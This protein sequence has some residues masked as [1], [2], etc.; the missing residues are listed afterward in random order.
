MVSIDGGTAYKTS[1]MDPN[2]P[3]YRQWY[4]SPTLSDGTHNIAITHI[5][6]TAVD[7]AVITAGPQTNLAGLTLI[8]DDGNPVM[9]Y[10]GS[11]S[12]SNS[13]TFS[14]GPY[15]GLPYGNTTH[16]TTSAGASV[17]VPFSGMF[18]LICETSGQ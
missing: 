8:V 14:G 11:W 4:Q 2:P 5:A 7:Y 3:S 12:Q 13:L 10:T 1:Y 6:A 17:T 18:N 15:T 16:R 9:R